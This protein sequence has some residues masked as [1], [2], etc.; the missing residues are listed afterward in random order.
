VSKY[1]I[2]VDTNILLDFY[3]KR[4]ESGLALL[5][6]FDGI[7][8]RLLTTYQVEMEFKR[9]RQAVIVDSLR[10]LKARDR[11]EHAAF[12]AESRSAAVLNRS[13]GGVNKRI[14]KFKARLKKVLAEPTRHDPVYKVAQRLFTD[15]TP[16]NLTRKKK[17]RQVLKRRAFRR[18]ILGY[19]PRKQHDTSMGDALNWEWIIEVA[20]QTGDHVVIVSRDSDY[21]VEVDG[22]TYVND[23]L[24]QEFRDRVSKKRQCLL[25]NRLAPAFKLAKVAVSKEAEQEEAEELARTRAVGQQVALWPDTGEKGWIAKFEKLIRDGTSQVPPESDG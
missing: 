6:A 25:F 7:H 11:V 9:N 21:G 1:L 14:E 20:Q 10:N 24:I 15:D 5:Q 8:D 18:F 22:Q 19:P 17:I 13:I 3:R 12:L 2:F 16:L 23:W 4:H